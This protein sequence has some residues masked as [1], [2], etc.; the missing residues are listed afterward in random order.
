MPKV[1]PVIYSETCR[2]KGTE[3]NPYRTV[4]QIHDLDGKLIAERDPE[5]EPKTEPPTWFKA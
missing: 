3:D 2:G 4:V 1:I 5:L